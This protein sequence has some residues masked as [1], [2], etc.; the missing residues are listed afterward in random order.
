NTPLPPLG[1]LPNVGPTQEGA[2]SLAPTQSG[3][4]LN[5]QIIYTVQPGDTLSGIAARF[6]STVEAIMLQNG[7]S[8][9]NRI[10]VGQKLVILVG[11]R[12]TQAAAPKT[13]SATFT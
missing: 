11:A 12:L 10:R 8:D 3:P 13:P 1:T 5:G 6:D 2:T 7:L 9:P 4:I